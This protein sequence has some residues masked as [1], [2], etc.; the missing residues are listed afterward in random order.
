MARTVRRVL[1]VTGRQG[2]RLTVVVS[3]YRDQVWVEISPPFESDIAILTPALVDR[4]IE[5]L[6]WGSN[7]ARTYGQTKGGQK[8]PSEI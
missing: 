4:L 3:V 6:T 2:V 5:T 7:E 1:V 8:E